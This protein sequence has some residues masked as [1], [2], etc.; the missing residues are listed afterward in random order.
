MTKIKI[1]IISYGRIGKVHMK[2]L[3][4]NPDFE[5]VMVCDIIEDPDFK[6]DYPAIPFVKDY[7]EVLANPAVEAVLIGTPTKFHPSQIIA[8]AK[9]GKHIFCEKP[10]GSELDEIMEA[11]EAVKEAGV[12][13]Q[14]GFNRRFDDDFLNIKARIAE[15]GEPQILKITSRDPG[16]PPL[17]YVKGSGGL[18]MDMAIHDFDMARY[19]FGEVK[20]VSAKGGA[21]IDP[22]ITQYDDIDTAITT[23][24]F[25]N[26]AMAVV[27]N[28][29]QAVY[30]YDQRLEAFG[31][32]GMLA[33]SNHTDHNT[34]F[35]GSDHIQSGKPQLFFLER[36][37]KSYDTELKFFADSIKNNAPIA[38]S[39]ED[40]IM[41]VKIAKSAKEALVTGQ[42]IAIE[43]I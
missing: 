29:R 40:G 23:L 20:T 2:N 27:D 16:M 7:D 43:K 1:A 38:C 10:V 25:E 36:Y 12:K 35:S 19:M 6:E 17:D 30:G 33:N 22:A 39:F 14:L 34:I 9:A 3:A 24:T 21:L 5:V 13:F 4:I 42:T 8:A 37:L 31:S 41:A 32:K 18:F 26:G 11:Y 28:S 15:I